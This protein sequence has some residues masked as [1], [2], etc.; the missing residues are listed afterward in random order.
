MLGAPEQNVTML[1]PRNHDKL[2]PHSYVNPEV[3]LNLG[4]WFLY[5]GATF[6]LA[7]RVWIKLTR[8]HGMWWDDWILVVTWVGT[9]P[10]SS[11]TAVANGQQGHP[12]RE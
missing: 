12:Y 11:F 7:L 1:S 3:P 6:F 5:A 10:S 9:I 4:I 2:H 8:R